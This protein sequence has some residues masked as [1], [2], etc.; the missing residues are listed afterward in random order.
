MCKS[1]GN[2]LPYSTTYHAY[3]HTHTHISILIY[4]YAHMCAHTYHTDITTECHR[5]VRPC[6]THVCAHTW[7][8]QSLRGRPLLG[9][10]ELHWVLSL[11]TCST[12][13]N[14]NIN[15]DT[16]VAVV[17][18]FVSCICKRGSTAW[19]ATHALRTVTIKV[20][21]VSKTGTFYDLYCS[22]YP[23]DHA[24]LL[25]PAK[26]GANTNKQLTSK[27]LRSQT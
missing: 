21:S 2:P 27:V 26:N 5:D 8:L 11:A 15:T 4:T 6:S 17:T 25:H 22:R 12:G 7:F 1:M 18:I 14:F 3:I 24:F 13:L 19:T 10:F 23:A 16:I 9:E 20:Q